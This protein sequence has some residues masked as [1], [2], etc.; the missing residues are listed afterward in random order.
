MQPI[1][2]KESRERY[3]RANF[4]MKTLEDIKKQNQEQEY[5]VHKIPVKYGELKIIV[6]DGVPHIT[7]LSDGNVTT[8][9]AMNNSNSLSII[10]MKG[11]IE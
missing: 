7:Y 9:V 8:L 3:G 11:D 5:E 2:N 4:S 1:K 6:I 10:A